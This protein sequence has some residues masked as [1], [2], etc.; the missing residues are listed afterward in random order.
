M[1]HSGCIV[2]QPMR[3]TAHWACTSLISTCFG[4]ITRV[5]SGSSLYLGICVA[6]ILPKMGEPGAV[7]ATVLKKI[8]ITCAT[9]YQ[10]WINCTNV[11]PPH[12]RRPY[13]SNNFLFFMTEIE[14]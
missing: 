9:N 5:V 12:P 6:K 10:Y 4:H 13:T 14:E 11:A 3:T 8:D 7:T 1:K 2:K